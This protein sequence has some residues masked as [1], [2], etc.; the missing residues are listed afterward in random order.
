MMSLREEWNAIVKELSDWTC[1]TF[2]EGYVQEEAFD[3]LEEG[4]KEYTDGL[5]ILI[6]QEAD[7]QK[8]ELLDRVWYEIEMCG[9]TSCHYVVRAERN[10]LQGEE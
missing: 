3:I 5:Y 9:G 10:K 6:Q 2:T 4:I 8:L 7:R 1:D